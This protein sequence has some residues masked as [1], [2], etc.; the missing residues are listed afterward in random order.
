[1]AV[2]SGQLALE[3]SDL[4]KT[5]R[6]SG[7][8]NEPVRALNGLNLAVAHGTVFVLLGPNGAGKSTTV[9]IFTTLSR[10]D[11][12]TARVMGIDVQKDPHAVRLAIGYVSQK[13]GSD[14]DATG[15]ENLLLHGRVYGFSRLGP[16][17]PGP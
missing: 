1:M 8:G 9:K 14:P 7:R 16:P 3:A 17:R 13:S 2:P 11:S 5:Y 6:A 12:G 10:A 4:V 15:R